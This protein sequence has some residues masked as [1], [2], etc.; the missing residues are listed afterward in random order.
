MHIYTVFRQINTL[1]ALTDTL[2]SAGAPGG[3]YRGFPAI[4]GNFWPVRAYFEENIPPESAGALLFEQ[5]PLFG[6]KRYI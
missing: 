5:V 4:L 2:V 1:C 3:Q 6:E